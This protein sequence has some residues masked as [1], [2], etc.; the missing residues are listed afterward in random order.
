MKP[1]AVRPKHSA[2]CGKDRTSI[3]PNEDQCHI[4]ALRIPSNAFPNT[5]NLYSTPTRY[6]EGNL[7]A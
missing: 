2:F 3:N 1:V 6:I 4:V 5:P 7:K